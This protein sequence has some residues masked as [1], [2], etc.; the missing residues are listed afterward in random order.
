MPYFAKYAA[1]RSD[2][3]EHISTIPLVGISI[4]LLVG[5]QLTVP[6]AVYAIFLLISALRLVRSP[7]EHLRRWGERR[8][9]AIVLGGILFFLGATAR[10]LIP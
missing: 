8:F 5:F 9:C 3:E 7:K 6:V 1:S 2:R 4:G 10:E